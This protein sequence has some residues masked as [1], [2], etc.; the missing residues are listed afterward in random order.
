MTGLRI[1]NLTNNNMGARRHI[2]L[3]FG[4]KD[5]NQEDKEENKEPEHYDKI[6]LYT[7]WGGESLED[8][9]RSALIR[10]EGRLND[11]SYLARIIFSEMIKDEI[12]ED[13]G[14][15]ISPYVTDDQYPTIE[16]DL[17]NQTVN[18]IPYKE[19]IGSDELYPPYP[20]DK[21]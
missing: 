2:A 14:F 12:L 17:E 10:G 4:P 3:D 11:V 7:H 8:V 19:F 18:E 1:I 20:K 16:V 9:L 21:N 13:T 6:Y 15:G 5:H